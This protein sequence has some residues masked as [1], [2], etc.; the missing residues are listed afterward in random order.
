[1]AKRMRL[2]DNL[3]Q[4]LALVF[5]LIVSVADLYG[6]GPWWLAVALCLTLGLVYQF[7]PYWWQP[8]LQLAAQAILIIPLL[9]LQ[10]IA[11]VLCFTFAVYAVSLFHDW[12][13]A[14]WIAAIAL[15]IGLVMINLI[16]WLE[17]LVAFIGVSVGLASFGFFTYARIQANLER[18]KS[19]KLLDELQEAHRQ[20]QDYAGRVEQLAAA[21]ERN[22]LAREMHDTLGHRLTVAA[23]QL[24][25]AQRLI[26]T[27]PE[28]AARMVATVR[29]QVVEALAELR[30]TVATLRTSLDADLPLT[31]SLT[32]LTKDFEDATGL[33]VHLDLPQEAPGLTDLQQTRPVPHG[34]GGANQHPA[35]RPRQPGLAV[36][37][38]W[39]WR[40]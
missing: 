37:D 3:F 19:Q 17:G 26:P 8:H 30:R 12:R 21:E 35:P 27:E 23:V 29:Q 32:R 10:P 7:W 9:F 22:R 6:D 34:S 14:A 25:G 38:L 13:G 39:R 2:S 20:L 4:Y 16:G 33:P 15:I 18:S 1:M 24:E 5:V 36:L 11:I 31:L 40:G 28:R